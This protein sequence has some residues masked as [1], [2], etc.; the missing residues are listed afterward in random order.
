MSELKSKF[1]TK[2]YDDHVKSSL[3]YPKESLGEIFTEALTRFPDK[4][5]CYFMERTIPYNEIWDYIQRFATFLQKNGLE[6]GDVVAINIANSPQFLI[7]QFGT[8]I[9]GGVTS[10]CSPLLS[11]E[12]LTYQLNDSEAK[13]IL[14]MD[15]IF[16]KILCKKGIL[17]N[18][19]KLKTVIATNI[20]EY[21]GLSKFK[22]FL[23]KL[24]GKIPKGKVMP[25]PGKNVVKFK[26]V[27]TTEIDLKSV[28]IDNDKDLAQ[29]Q[30]TGG[31]TGRPK[32]TELTHANMIAN[33]IQFDHW[34]DREKG[35][36]VIVSCFPYFHIA[37]LLVCDFSTYLSGTQVLIANP[38]DTDHLI[39]EIID[40]KP[41]VFANVPTLYM[42]II[43]NP[44]LANIPRSILDNINLY[45]SGA[46]PFPVESVREFEKS[47]YAENK[48]VEVY[49]MTEASPLVTSNPAIKQKKIGTV[50]LPF[51]DTEFRLIDIESGKDVG[52]GETGEILIKG[53]QIT[54]GYYNKPGPTAKT[55]IDGWLH[56]GDVGVFDDDGYLKI[57]DRTKDML[58]VSGYKVYSVHVEDIMTK[59][60]DIEIIAIIGVKNP[61][62]PGSEIVKAV[63]QLKEGINATEEVKERIKTYAKKSLSSYENPKIWEFKDEIPLTSIGKV[64]KRELRDVE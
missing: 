52:I 36:D 25:W 9:A 21:M 29:L 37:G 14:T 41:T 12:E 64:L 56:T 8:W 45:V 19:P 43:N 24:I 17:D 30:Y 13:F 18:L 7:A 10:G 63:I 60:E 48:L 54:R 22:Q 33:L 16:D 49:G 62:R 61:D 35:T 2:S 42:M 6:K 53:P 58:N 51:P 31:T 44:K 4:P 34:L 47:M 39:N 38:R 5:A 26:D 20:S 57:V 50:G 59:Q 3:K 27:M 1:W 15:I 11:D 55:I 46:A 32:G 23:G 40:K 28:S